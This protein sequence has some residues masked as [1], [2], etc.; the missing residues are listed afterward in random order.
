MLEI[1]FFFEKEKNWK[2]F[3]KYWDNCLLYFPSL[4]EF[5]YCVQSAENIFFSFLPDIPSCN[6][7]TFLFWSLC[8]RQYCIR[9]C[10]LYIKL[11]TKQTR[12]VFPMNSTLHHCSHFPSLSL[13]FSHFARFCSIRVSSFFFQY[14]K[15]EAS[16]CCAKC[17]LKVNHLCCASFK[18]WQLLT[19]VNVTA[20]LV[21]IPDEE[22]HGVAATTHD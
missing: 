7:C 5:H 10:D 3:K 17:S 8:F 14:G 4:Q 21:L 19:G 16:Q 13:F 18:S 20:E 1:F 2:I 11:K 15:S 22:A 6:L 12:S 9:S